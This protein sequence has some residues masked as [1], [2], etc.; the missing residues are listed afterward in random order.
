MKKNIILMGVSGAGKTTVGKELAKELDL[1]FFDADDFHSRE[2]RDKMAAGIALSDE[3]R[4]SWLAELRNILIAHRRIGC[5]LACSALKEKY[6]TYLL[7]HTDETVFVYLEADFEFIE[8]RLKKR[9]DHFMPPGLL[10]SQFETLE[11]P[12]RAIA[13]DAALPVEVIC[14]EIENR[15]SNDV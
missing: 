15:L 1:T 3:D 8:E 5:V 2:N 11:I 9:K 12:V 13:V 14:M 10:K 6:R 7:Q 4:K